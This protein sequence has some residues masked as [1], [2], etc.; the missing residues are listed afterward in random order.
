MSIE[1]CLMQKYDI[2]NH[3][4]QSVL[5]S[6]KQSFVRLQWISRA[7]MGSCFVVLGVTILFGY[8]VMS[9]NSFK[10]MDS[11]EVINHDPVR[12]IIANPI[13]SAD[14]EML[15]G[16]MV[17]II[18]GSVKTKLA[19]L[20]ESISAGQVSNKELL[21]L[22]ELTK[23]INAMRAV[24]TPNV[25]VGSVDQSVLVSKGSQ[26]PAILLKELSNLKLLVYLTIVSCG[27]MFV[28]SAGV[29]LQTRLI[30]QHHDKYRNLLTRQD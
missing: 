19:Q 1:S 25:G 29:W 28:A 20:Q 11:Y 12:E 13:L 21:L 26:N 17:S 16:Q 8:A 7:I 15:K 14:V 18:S 9:Q 24:S 3:S 6:H 27:L 2:Q 23:D 22:N 4:E 5:S 10:S 30:L